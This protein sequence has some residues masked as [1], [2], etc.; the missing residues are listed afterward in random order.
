M[1]ST[2]WF[3]KTGAVVAAA[4][5]AAAA[6]LATAADKP[7]SKTAAGAVVPVT[8]S[9]YPLPAHAVS[10]RNS[11]QLAA[12]LRRR[13]PTDIV[14]SD[15]SYSA[16]EPFRDANGHRL[17]ARHLGR[18]VLR[19]GLTIGGDAAPPGALVRGLAFDVSDPASSADGAAI[20]VWGTA[21]GVRVLDVTLQGDHVTAAGL[22]VRQPEGFSAA[23]L[24]VRGFTDYGV[25]VDANDSARQSLEQPVS[26]RNLDIADIS[27]NPPGSSNGTAE[28]CLWVGNPGVVRTVRLRRCA[29]SGLWTGTAA[30]GLLVDRIDI[31]GTPTGVYVEHFTRASTFERLLVRRGVR[32]GLIAE[33]AD[34]AWGT[35]PASVDNVVENSRFESSLVGVYL[36]AGTTRTTIRRTSF[37]YQQLAA[38]GDYQGVGN[39]YYG[40]DYHAILPGAV[41]VTNSHISAATPTNP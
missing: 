11:E 5:A 16:P 20:T 38:I 7:G 18:A 12:A 8:P 1:T 39:A 30:T 13:S 15:G 10:V 9:P 35:K 37:A 34:P 17:Y 14:L 40:N 26:L 19:A 33:W 24:V 29:W 41:R 6:A 25:F 2:S 3:A 32:V 36:D 31:D 28:A 4:L 27:R 22:R 23:R 21:T